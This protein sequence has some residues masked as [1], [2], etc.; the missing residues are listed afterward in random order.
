M[1][2]NVNA[3][4]VQPKCAAILDGRWRPAAFAC[5]EL[6]VIGRRRK[7]RTCR[8]N[9][10][11]ARGAKLKEHTR[12]ASRSGVTA[13]ISHDRQRPACTAL[14]HI[15]DGLPPDNLPRF[16]GQQLDPAPFHR[17]PIATVLPSSV[18]R[19]DHHIFEQTVVDPFLGAGTTGVIALMLGAKFV[20]LGQRFLG[21]NHI[22][23]PRRA[24]RTTCG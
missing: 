12:K 24:Y 10:W 22:R 11:S 15:E 1:L 17:A 21:S 18:P 2:A 23:R 19:T 20:G 8:Q 16:Y 4:N 3:R 7:V 6:R 13:L 14:P 9:Q 5:G